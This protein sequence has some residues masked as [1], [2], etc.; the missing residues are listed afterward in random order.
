MTFYF[1]LLPMTFYHQISFESVNEFYPISD[2]SFRNMTFEQIA[3]EDYNEEK[4]Y[5]QK[6][7]LWDSRLKKI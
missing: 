4:D 5:R 2:F 1:F 6:R 7:E 3:D